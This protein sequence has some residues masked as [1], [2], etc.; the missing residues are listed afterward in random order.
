MSRH[1]VVVKSKGHRYVR[2]VESYRNPDGAPRSRIVENL[3]RLDRLEAREADFLA[4]LRAR[5][6]R[7]VEGAVDS[8]P[9]SGRAFDAVSAGCGAARFKLGAAVVRRV[10]KEALH[11]PQ[12]FRYLQGKRRI[13]YSYDKAAFL[14]CSQR[15]LHEG[16]KKQA[17][18]ER[19]SSIISFADLR[20]NN[21]VYRVLDRLQEDKKAIVRHLNRALDKRFERSVSAIFYDVP[22]PAFESRSASKMMLGLVMDEFG[23]PVDYELTG[24]ATAEWEALCPVIQRMRRAHELKRIVVVEE[25]GAHSHE[26]LS[27]LAAL[28]G[29]FVLVQGIECCTPGERRMLEGEA[30]FEDLLEGGKV[31]CRYK[32][33]DFD[34]LRGE[35]R[36]DGRRDVRWIVAYSAARAQ[37]DNAALD[38]AA[39]GARR[40]SARRTKAGAPARDL[41][42]VEAARS[43]AGY[44]VLRTNLKTKSPQDVLDIYRDLRRLEE[45][46][47]ISRT[48]LEDRPCFVWTENRLKGHFVNCFIS[49]V[50]EKYL[51]HELERGAPDMTA[52]M[53][54]D[55]LR[56]SEV[57]LDE[58]H[59][60]MPLY[61]RR[62]EGAVG[63]EVILRTVGLTPLAETETPSSLR[64]KLRL[65]RMVR[66]AG[67]PVGCTTEV[68]K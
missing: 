19:A 37:R 47:Q 64:R 34:G 52:E 22:M 38:Q 61:R 2:V 21:V 48:L 18:E 1:V 67:H 9:R 51:R 11:L 23:I 36:T 45:S 29:E 24:G 31:R 53:M 14:L 13:E 57:V 68:E 41:K 59:P 60:G 49:L 3:G 40:R 28:G 66:A 15:I 32:T 46:L 10:W 5:V 43:W 12:L 25:G 56:K 17:F 50:V 58:G 44:F 42:A 16:S 4:K 35:D 54:L 20:D 7:E 63:F 55:A 6:A 39:A 26:T 30:G 8:A 62:E 33:V 65:G 27:G